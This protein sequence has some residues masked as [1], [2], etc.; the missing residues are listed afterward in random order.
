MNIPMNI[1]TNMANRHIY[2]RMANIPC[3]HFIEMYIQIWVLYSSKY[4]SL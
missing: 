4:Y 2:F 3:D 1:L